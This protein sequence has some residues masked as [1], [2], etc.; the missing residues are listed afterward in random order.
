MSSQ[1]FYSKNADVL[2]ETYH[3]I[4]PEEI[5]A[6][7]LHYIPDTKALILDVGAGS[8]RDSS[9][10]AS[11]GH[12]VVAVEPVDEL[13]MKAQE[14]MN[15]SV[16][17]IKDSLPALN[18]VY[19]LDN[20]FELILLSAVWNHVAP[21]DRERAF[22]KLTNLLRPGGKLVITLR[23]GPSYGDRTFYDCSG[24]ELNTY[25]RKFMLQLLLEK[26]LSTRWDDQM[27]H[28]PL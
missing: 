12:E 24:E 2:H 13:R 19:K 11:K 7:W 3:K 4:S 18:E 27:F 15:P 23:K 8:G 22:R 5:H 6:D 14:Q 17:W 10:L 28:G 16:L 26:T 9:W 25:A 20:K 1:S 21:S